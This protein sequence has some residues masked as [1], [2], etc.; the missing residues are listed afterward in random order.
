MCVVSYAWTGSLGL[1]AK[2]MGTA[3]YAIENPTLPAYVESTQP[4][5]TYTAGLGNRPLA[6][7]IHT[8][9]EEHDL[10]KRN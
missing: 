6:D 4:P 5:A 7:K 9:K 1:M 8:A 3:Q 10:L 2:I